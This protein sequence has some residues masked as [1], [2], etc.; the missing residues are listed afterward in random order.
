MSNT[1]AQF[2][3]AVEIVGKLPPD[4]PAKPTTEDQLKFYAHFKQ[5][6]NG[7]CTGAAPGMFDFKGKAKYNAWKE[8]EG[9]SKEDAMSIYVVLL[10][11]MLKKFDDD[12]AS[13]KFLAE[14]EGASQKQWNSSM[15][16]ADGTQAAGQ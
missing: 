13:K 8:L 5:A 2:D 3:K 1:Q 14:L 4:G 9:M 10:R 16:A 6:K 12:E 11:D 15:K 7:D